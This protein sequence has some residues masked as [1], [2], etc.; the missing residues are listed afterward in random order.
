MCRPVFLDSADTC[1]PMC[2]LSFPDDVAAGTRA[3]AN[4][5]ATS[6]A[7]LVRFMKK[8]PL[9]GGGGWLGRVPART[10]LPP[11]AVFVNAA[12][13]TWLVPEGHRSC[14]TAPDSH[15]LRC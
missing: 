3:N 9:V 6:P 1:V 10:A 2:R 8:P 7:K 11:R 13:A 12:Q 4:A 15:R 14:G 5:A